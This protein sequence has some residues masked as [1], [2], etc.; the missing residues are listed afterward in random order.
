MTSSKSETGA[1]GSSAYIPEVDR[2]I[3]YVTLAKPSV[4]LPWE[5]TTSFTV[6]LK[7]TLETKLLVFPNGERS[8][9][10]GTRRQ[11]TLSEGRAE[12]K[13]FPEFLLP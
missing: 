3:V 6:D 11:W 10:S 4:E 2:D 9:P 1:S 13:V 12:N 7:K 5:K 8:A